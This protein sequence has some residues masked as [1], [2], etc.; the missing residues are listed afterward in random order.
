MYS[1]D[2]FDTLITRKTATPEGIFALVQ[3]KLIND[4]NYSNISD[5][6]R[7]NFFQLRIN[8]EKLARH[9]CNARGD[10][11]LT[12]N[13]IYE[14]LATTGCI[15]SDK[16]D[17]LIMLEKEVEYENIIGIDENIN[18]IKDL[19]K[20]KEHVI[21]ISDMY[22]D[23]DTVRN[24]LLKIDS[25][26]KDIKIYVSSKYKKS[27][28]CGSL[29]KIIK[30]EEKVEYNDWIHC[31]D[32][33]IS[34]IQSPDKL[35][36]QTQHYKFE[37]FMKC[38][39]QVMD[40]NKHNVFI[41]MT[42]GA[43]RNSRLNNKCKGPS[44][45]GAA[46]GGPILFQYVY[47]IINES[48]QKGIKRLY[49]IARDGFILKQI[50]DI[51][52]KKY[53]Y[54]IKTYYIYGS[55]LA[56]R[57]AGI[58]EN[59]NDLYKFM[60]WSYA[61]KIKSISDLADFF[62]I[63]VE[64]V[65]EYI[66]GIFNTDNIEVTQ[67][68]LK[69]IIDK[70]NKDDSFKKYIINI[71]KDSRE[72]VIEYL[73]QEVDISDDYFAF[74]DLSG[75]GFTQGCLADIMGD[76]YENK[77]KTFFFKM[78]DI[79]V[80]NN[81]IY[82]NFMPS[83]LNLSLI[84]EAICRAPHGQTMHY[85][86]VNQKIIPVL[87]EDEGNELINHGFNEYLYGIKKFTENYLDRISCF[88]MNDLELII[89]YVEYITKNPDREVLEFFAKMPNSV[90]GREKNVVE[91]APRLSMK[92]IRSIFLGGKNAIEKYYEGSSLEY[93][94]L[95]ASEKDKNKIEYYKKIKESFRGNVLRRVYK[96]DYNMYGLA[97]EF[98]C[99]LL[100]DR[101]IL[102]GAG[103][104][105]IDLYKKINGTKNKK[106]VQ[107]VDKNYK[108]I[109]RTLYRRKKIISPLEIGNIE[110]DNVVIGVLNY[111]IAMEIRKFLIL[112]GINE[113]KIVWMELF[114]LWK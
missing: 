21:L 12:L 64:K 74:V 72:L 56:W 13:D 99:E 3:E 90:S 92:Q 18:K 68:V 47:W 106:V 34:D 108:H 32:N 86:R 4:V 114:N 24:M 102:Y 58:S 89:K 23:E 55:R 51:I 29:Y 38:E 49:F 100:G 76:F 8:A 44:A 50:A 73:K 112:Q 25:I 83:F 30:N 27:K 53:S 96:I 37:E 97:S 75:G 35:G 80:M 78:D 107:W 94:L 31:G 48:I 9:V 39:E 103:K 69:I 59:N 52:I 104:L 2:V 54:D 42:V 16:I 66:R 101:V 98:P 11:E 1:F 28:W 60:R 5:Y 93:S 33:I 91:F 22:L 81:C 71:H 62:R 20:Q 26:F 15:D 43:S 19:K 7:N 65:Q 40:G 6:I 109:K 85:K 111:D 95:R 63:P 82:Y 87:K 105:G 46:L 79:N 61:H 41:Q 36:I 10:E 14:A 113:E 17:T 110:Y 84:I 67:P 70:L 77:I 57:L 45:I 88:H